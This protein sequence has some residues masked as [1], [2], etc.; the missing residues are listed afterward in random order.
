[1]SNTQ[2]SV[3]TPLWVIGAISILS[4]SIGLALVW[5]P[6]T[7]ALVKDY[8]LENPEILTQA[9]NNLQ[10]KET[11]KRLSAVGGAMAKPFGNAALGS[12]NPDITI[13]EFTDYGCGF[14]RKSVEDVDRLVKTDPRIRVV[15]RE[16]PILSPAS[17]QAARWALAAAK[18]GKHKAFHDAMFAKGPPNDATI[19]AAASTA[20]LDIAKAEADAAGSDV[21]AEIESNLKMMQQIG[22]SGTPTF[23]MGD[24][25]IEGAVG[26]NALKDA[27]AKARSEN[28]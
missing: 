14:C 23:I 7:Q 22:F 12:A 27:I 8:I 1:M 13:I 28:S 25:V 18:Q 4:L 26:Y 21:T 17:E 11:A 16:V 5:R 19:R 24:Q 15:Y 20:G 10:K 3:T 6:A 9:M 2:K